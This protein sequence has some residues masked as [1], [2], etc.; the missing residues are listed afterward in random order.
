MTDKARIFSGIQPSA[1]SLHIGNYIGALL[2]WKALQDAY[3][4]IFCIVDLHALTV[5]YDPG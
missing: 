3:D 2:Q 5:P 4:A 1:D